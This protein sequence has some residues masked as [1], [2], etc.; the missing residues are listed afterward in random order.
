MKEYKVIFTETV[1]HSFIF[2]AE[3]EEDAENKFLE[4]VDNC[5]VDFSGGEV[6]DSEYYITAAD[7]P[8][9]V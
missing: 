2:E 9:L 3:S 4:A 6:S 1:V 8:E 5:E 7:N